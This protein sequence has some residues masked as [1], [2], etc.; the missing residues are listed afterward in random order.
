MVDTFTISSKKADIAYMECVGFINLS[1]DESDITA[2][3]E[4]ADKEKTT[5]KSSSIIQKVKDLA[6]K[7]LKF[8]KDFAESAKAKLLGDK[9]KNNPKALE[10]KKAEVLDVKKIM[11]FR[12]SFEK[13]IENAKTVDEV[14]A[15]VAEYE[16]KNKTAGVAVA[17][18]A[19]TTIGGMIVSGKLKKVSDQMISE[20]NDKCAESYKKMSL[21]GSEHMNDD[22]GKAAAA[23]YFTDKTNLEKATKRKKNGNLKLKKSVALN[24]MISDDMKSVKDFFTSAVRVVSGAFKKDNGNTKGETTDISVTESVDDLTLFGEDLFEESAFTDAGKKVSSVIQ[25]LIEKIKKFYEELKL[26]FAEAKLRAVLGSKTAKTKMKIR[27][28]IKDK[29]IRKVVDAEI[30]AYNAFIINAKKIE[31]K[32]ISGKINVY[33]VSA[34]LTDLEKAYNEQLEK[35]R[36]A[37]KQGDQADTMYEDFVISKYLTDL[38]SYQDKILVGMSKS[39]TSELNQLKNDVEK[40]EKS[41]DTNETVT[42]ISKVKNKIASVMSRVNTKTVNVVINTIGLVVSVGMFAKAMGDLKKMSNGTFDIT[43][44]AEDPDLSAFFGE[45]IFGNTATD[46]GV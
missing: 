22:I 18:V 45:E 28:E 44:S 26:K 25:A 20:L 16:K 14:D 8:F 12:K 10:K 30:K 27:F 5:D 32:F 13:K 46:V 23:E 7:I 31:Q 9:I 29:T 41:N 17:A 40:N 21:P 39:I 3:T 4:A 6:A 15:I 37:D 38:R 43:E 33:Q 36:S 35:V 1:M 34:E 24:K 11:A 42:G 2:F 19:L